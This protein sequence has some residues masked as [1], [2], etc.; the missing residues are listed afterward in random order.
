MGWSNQICYTDQAGENS[1]DY[2]CT[3]KFSY[4][5]YYEDGNAEEYAADV[6]AF[7]FLILIVLLLCIIICGGFYYTR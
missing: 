1:Y 4:E 6:A 2:F 3:E 5:V 7:V